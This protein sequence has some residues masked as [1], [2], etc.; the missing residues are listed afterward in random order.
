MVESLESKLR[1]L[2]KQ[3][4][5]KLEPVEFSVYIITV[6][7]EGVVWRKSVKTGR[8]MRVTPSAV[9]IEP[10]EPSEKVRELASRP[11]TES[12]LPDK[13]VPA[14]PEPTAEELEAQRMEEIRARISRDFGGP[15]TFGEGW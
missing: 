7:R 10:W 5:A 2:E 13:F 6:D 3:S 12:L 4:A 8:A 15:T 14:I 11:R 1:R 9:G